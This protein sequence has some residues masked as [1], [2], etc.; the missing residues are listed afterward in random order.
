MNIGCGSTKVHFFMDSEHAAT[1]VRAHLF[2]SNPFN[3]IIVFFA[4]HSENYKRYKNDKQDTTNEKWEL[5][6]DLHIW[7]HDWFL[8]FT[9]ERGAHG[10]LWAHLTLRIRWTISTAQLHNVPLAVTFF[11]LLLILV[12]YRQGHRLQSYVLVIRLGRPAN[13]SGFLF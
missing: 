1:T 7:G 6:F 4:S 12:A 13:I 5:F 11:F 10:V 8:P 9:D 3:I 2:L